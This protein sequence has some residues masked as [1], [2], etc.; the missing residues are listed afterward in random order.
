V[1]R[2]SEDYKLGADEPRLQ[3]F[4]SFYSAD[5]MPPSKEKVMPGKPLIIAEWSNL[6][7]KKYRII[8]FMIHFSNRIKYR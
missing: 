5:F 2:L 6:I 4:E 8:W 7:G 3:E 1:K